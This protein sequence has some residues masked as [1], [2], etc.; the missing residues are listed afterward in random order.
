MHPGSCCPTD[1]PLPASA[2]FLEH[3]I[4][5]PVR[6]VEDTAEINM[7]MIEA[8]QFI[9]ER[10]CFC[11]MTAGLVKQFSFQPAQQPDAAPY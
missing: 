10:L 6:I 5:Q 2:E 3:L 9:V 11:K 8:F 7:R 4:G 1:R